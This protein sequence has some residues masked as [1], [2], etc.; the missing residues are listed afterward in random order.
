ML[1][2][3]STPPRWHPQPPMDPG[4][5]PPFPTFFLCAWRQGGIAHLALH[6][7]TPVPPP[8]TLSR[9]PLPPS[10][11][12]RSQDPKHP[13]RAS[14]EPLYHPS[15]IYTGRRMDTRGSKRNRRRRRRRPG[16]AACGL[17]RGPNV[18][19]RGLILIVHPPQS[20]WNASFSPS[21]PRLCFFVLCLTHASLVFRVSH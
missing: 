8:Q 3:S 18:A 11:V 4:F 14:R 16:L 12:A 6:F 5:P 17:S 9:N 15:H 2:Q 1:S 7:A 21:R 10:V 19:L 13:L 20:V